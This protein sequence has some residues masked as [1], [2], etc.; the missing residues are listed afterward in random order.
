MLRVKTSLVLHHWRPQLC[1]ICHEYIQTQTSPTSPCHRQL[2]TV[3]WI[4]LNL[5]KISVISSHTHLLSFVAKGRHN[6]TPRYWWRRECP[7]SSMA[8]W[9]RTVHGHESISSDDLCQKKFTAAVDQSPGELTS[10]WLLSAMKRMLVSLFFTIRTHQGFRLV[11]HASWYVRRSSWVQTANLSRSIVWLLV[12]SSFDNNN[13]IL[14]LSLRKMCQL[15]AILKLFDTLHLTHVLA[16]VDLASV[17]T[18]FDL[19]MSS[20]MSVLYKKFCTFS[21]NI[22]WLRSVCSWWLHAVTYSAYAGC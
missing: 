13:V 16:S 15:D 7:C 3:D 19:Y 11:S 10:Y 20:T 2:L 6:I 1:W 9:R 14:S 21:M 18:L 17:F 8:Q 5:W 4:W 12:K 22:F